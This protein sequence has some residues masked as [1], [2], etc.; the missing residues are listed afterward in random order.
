MTVRR[1][2]FYVLLLMKKVSITALL[3]GFVFPALSALQPKEEVSSPSLSARVK[4]RFSGTEEQSVL[5]GLVWRIR[6]AHEMF[7]LVIHYNMLSI[8]DR[9]ETFFIPEKII[10]RLE[11][12]ARLHNEGKGKNPNR[13]IESVLE[14]AGVLKLL[15]EYEVSSYVEHI[16]REGET[17]FEDQRS[18]AIEALGRIGKHQPLP[19]TT[20][21]FLKNLFFEVENPNTR[22]H[23]INTFGNLVKFHPPDQF[24]LSR[25]AEQMAKWR[26]KP[27]EIKIFEEQYEA[28]LENELNRPGEDYSAASQSVS[29]K[30]F[31]EGSVKRAV[32]RRAKQEK[33]PPY[34]SIIQTYDLL[35]TALEEAAQHTPLP[36]QLIEEI[37]KTSAELAPVEQRSLLK[38]ILT[39][40]EDLPAKT[41]LRIRTFL[42]GNGAG[43]SL[44][45]TGLPCHGTL[46]SHRL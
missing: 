31:E 19:Q 29:L 25:L 4:N 18:D 46:L 45:E 38:R 36:L 5:K 32:K 37:I 7:P 11:E 44:P 21:R 3:A 30:M 1:F 43:G 9:A 2:L 34:L 35:F 23:V 6:P 39:V 12:I 10:Q 27:D 26:I 40:R 13:R 17:F 8:A 16:K 42:S 24:F 28:F 20:A 41:V 33:P 22:L 15:P 14:S